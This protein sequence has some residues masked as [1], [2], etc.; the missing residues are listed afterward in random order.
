MP[1]ASV[2]K[3]KMRGKRSKMTNEKIND[4]SQG[5]M[6][7]GS[8]GLPE[9]SISYAMTYLSTPCGWPPLK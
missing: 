3:Q 6:A 4:E 7:R 5:H 8:H 2:K 9:V 1:Y